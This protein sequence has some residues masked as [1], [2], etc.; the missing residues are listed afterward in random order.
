MGILDVMKRDMTDLSASSRR[1]R[2]VPQLLNLPCPYLSQ[3]LSWPMEEFS[4]L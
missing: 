2:D 1:G 4:R 3:I